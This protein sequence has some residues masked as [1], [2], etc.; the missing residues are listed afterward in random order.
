[1]NSK[2]FKIGLSLATVFLMAGCTAEELADALDE[3]I[4]G[5]DGQTI[6]TDPET[7]APDTPYTCNES[8]TFDGKTYTMKFGA[9]GKLAADC[10]EGIVFAAGVT[11]LTV[12]QL[13][14]T[15]VVDFVDSDGSIN[16][17]VQTDLQAGTMHYTGTSSEN[18]SFD[19]TEEYDVNNL[20]ITINDAWEL[21]DLIW[22]YNYTQQ[23]SDCPT[24]FSSEDGGAEDGSETGVFT[25]NATITDSDGGTSHIST[26]ES[27]Q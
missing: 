20:P 14:A 4:V 24:W 2:I 15:E 27:I 9:D 7:V 21:D 18:G 16:A 6:T 17:V 12:T 3:Q 19:C 22:L 1:M 25:T 26:Y 11:S 8:G 13:T 5:D 10:T 23:T